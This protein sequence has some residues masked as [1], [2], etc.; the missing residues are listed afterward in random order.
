MKKITLWVAAGC[1]VAR[2]ALDTGSTFDLFGV[3]GSSPSDVFAV[4]YAAEVLHY[5][6]ST[7]TA[8]N[9][10]DPYNLQGLWGFFGH[11]RRRG[12]RHRRTLQRQRVEHSS[13]HP[14]AMTLF[15]PIKQKWTTC[16][17]S[18]WNPCFAGCPSGF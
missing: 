12:R 1:V 10:G 13:E 16:L 7:W 8:I 3:W 2:S 14:G 17:L 4:G 11:L 5:D 6:G 18:L 15:V 9:S